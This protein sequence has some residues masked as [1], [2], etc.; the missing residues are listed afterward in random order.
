[1]KL[2]HIVAAAATLATLSAVASARVHVVRPTQ[3]FFFPA[4]GDYSRIARNVVING[5]EAI[6]IL[7]RPGGRQAVLFQRGADR[8][9]SQG[10]T[11]LDVTTTD[12]GWDDLALGDGVLAV[13]IGLDMHIL[14]R[15]NGTWVEAGTAGTPQPVPYLAASGRTILAGRRGCDVDA[16]VYEKS[17]GSG[18]WR[19]NGRLT[20]LPAMCASQT[21]LALHGNLALLRNAANDIGVFHRSGSNFD[22]VQEATLVP[23][24]GFLFFGA[25]PPTLFGDTAI[26]SG[27]HYRRGLSGWVYQDTIEPLDAADVG[28]MF[29]PDYNG[30]LLIALQSGNDMH[31]IQSA[32]IWKPDTAGKF[33]QVAFLGAS[34]WTRYADLSGNTAVVTAEDSGDLYVEFFD[35]PAPLVAPRAVANDF[36]ARDVSD[37]QQTM[38][39]GFALANAG[40]NYVYRQS[41]T[42]GETHAVFANTEWANAQTIEA[43]LKPTAFDGN[44]RWLGLGVRYVDAANQYYV[45]LRSSG[46]LQLKKKVDGVFTTLDEVDMPVTVGT[47]YHVQLQALGSA[48]SA[49]AYARGSG[50]WFGVQAQDSTFTHGRTALMTYRT[51]A[52]FDNVYAAPTQT[53]GVASKYSGE[54]PDDFG[55]RFTKIGGNWTPS[56][57]PDGSLVASQT[58]RGGDA[59]AFYGTPIDDQRIEVALRLDAFGS[60]TSG[61]WIGVLA[62]WVDARNFYYLTL[63][64]TGRLEIRKQVNGV[65]TTLKSVPFTTTPGRFYQLRF[66]VLGNELH[67]FVDDRYVAGAID[68]DIA[69]GQYGV[70]SYRGAFSYKRFYVAQP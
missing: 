40:S 46:K 16:N 24:A 25:E 64:S 29:A 14:E 63:R 70:G 36:D 13:R 33:T 12:Q 42:S 58:D 30:D 48:L 10:P 69:Q 50:L 45:T 28:A 68:N 32:Y 11:L 65:I 67:A 44:D 37:I 31:A 60:S 61:A 22:W 21:G 59:R 7:T 9:W 57:E 23:P 2:L 39:S 52:D 38:G 49:Q 53:Y 51:R 41:N 34:A 18:V 27:L 1:M 19:V 56:E 17:T 47:T 55:D 43:D 3:S 5:D 66:E 54:G 4:N 62:R 20:G 8:R 26:S 35:L 15:R 6:A